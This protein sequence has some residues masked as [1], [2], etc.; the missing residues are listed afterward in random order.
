MASGAKVGNLRGHP[1]TNRLTTTAAS[2]PAV[3]HSAQCSVVEQ[4]EIVTFV[5]QQNAAWSVV[6]LVID[7]RGRHLVSAKWLAD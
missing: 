5:D 2:V 3:E 1:P 4:S 6:E 7:R